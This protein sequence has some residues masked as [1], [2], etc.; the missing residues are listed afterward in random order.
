MIYWYE[1]D[2]LISKQLTHNYVKDNNTVESQLYL[3]YIDSS[4]LNSVLK[5]QTSND[6]QTFISSSITIHINCESNN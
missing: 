6:N 2:E 4:H 5:C 1:N 3:Q